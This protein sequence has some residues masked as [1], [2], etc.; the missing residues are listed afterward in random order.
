VSH[1]SPASRPPLSELVVEGAARH[2]GT[3]RSRRLGS[4]AVGHAAWGAPAEGCP[5]ATNPSPTSLCNRW[6]TAHRAG[7][8]IASK[9]SRPFRSNRSRSASCARW[10]GS[11]GRFLLPGRSPTRRRSHP[12]G[13]RQPQVRDPGSTFRPQQGVDPRRTRPRVMRSNHH[14]SA[15][16]W[17]C[18]SRG[19]RRI[20]RLSPQRIRRPGY[21]LGYPRQAR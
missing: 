14:L 9:A 19:G 1:R 12:A 18:R 20:R 8:T 7:L 6:A 17:S 16:R 21:G 10:R 11:A 5:L 15:P 2:L 3:G 4:R 13:L